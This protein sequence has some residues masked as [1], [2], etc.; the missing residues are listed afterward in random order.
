MQT[1][2]KRGLQT[3]LV[4]GGLLMLG[5]GIASADENV[6]PDTPAGPLDVNLSVPVQ[7]SQNAVGTLGKQV[8]LPE[9]NKEI[10]TKPVTDVAN[11]ALAPVSKT[12]ALQ[13]AA[14]ATGALNSAVSKAGAAT[15]K[16]ER[17]QQ[18]PSI[19]PN[20]DPF[21][22]NKIVG[23]LVVPIQIT[24][25]ALGV[26][27]NASVDSDKTQS[28]SH[29]TDVNTS[30]AHGGLA[31][32]VV[33]LDWALPVQISGNAGGLFGSGHTTGSATQS[34]TA[35]GETTTDGTNGGLS[36]NVIAPQGATPVQVS[37]NA[38]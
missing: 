28:Y 18:G 31:G 27:G 8:N 35:T 32:N 17:I 24:G 12:G 1:W 19:Q 13:A 2:A 23:N 36:G 38:L 9:V 20:G 7:I 26:L 10:S 30:G 25:N 34:A 15:A 5:T 37:G 3:A 21:M 16:G 33:N 14:P 4:T 29:N 22:G 11:K 6:N